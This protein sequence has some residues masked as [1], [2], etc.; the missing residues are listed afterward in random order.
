MGAHFLAPGALYLDDLRTGL[1]QHER[2]QWA[3]EQ[4]CEIE[5]KKPRQRLS[6]GTRFA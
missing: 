6:H 5:D 2:C 4:S 1:R 3:R